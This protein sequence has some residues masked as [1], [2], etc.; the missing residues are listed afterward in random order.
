MSLDRFY[1]E[2]VTDILLSCDFISIENNIV[3][4]NLISFIYMEYYL[5]IC[6][7]NIIF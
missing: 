7:D 5:Y 4:L 3:K 6:L 2:Q 1:L